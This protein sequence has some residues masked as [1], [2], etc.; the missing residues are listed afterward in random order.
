MA[1]FGAVAAGPAETCARM[2]AAA[3]VFV[4][5][6]GVRYGSTVPARPE[7]SYT[8][9]EF[10]TA[11]K[12]GLPRLILLIRE[13]SPSLPPVTQSA[14]ERARQSAFRQRLRQGG[15]T[16]AWATSPADVELQLFQA[17]TEMEAGYDRRRWM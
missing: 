8:E 14:E 7:L 10:E 15:L 4:G 5:I 2:I 9:L 16:I 12:L 3:D 1:Y 11:T 6:I 13:D 17:L